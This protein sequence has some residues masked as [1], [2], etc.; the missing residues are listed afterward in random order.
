MAACAEDESPAGTR[1][2]ALIALLYAAGGLRRAEVVALNREDYDR[3]TGALTVR[4]KGRKERLVY[5]DNG[6]QDAL[7]DWLVLRGDEPGPLFWP[8]NKGGVLQERRL[9][10]QAVYNLL[11]KRAAGGVVKPVSPHDLRRT[12]VSDLL[13]AGAMT[14]AAPSSATC[15]RPGPTSAPWPSWPVTPRSRPP[16]ATTAAAKPPSSGPAGCCMSPGG[17]GCE[18]KKSEGSRRMR[19]HGSDC[20]AQSNGY[21]PFTPPPSL[22]F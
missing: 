22:P 16:P 11:R 12:F 7:E 14:C 8:V 9:T 3:E 13:E 10:G 5:V 17:D 1:D 6:A 4:G 18:A 15:W 19:P 20:P 21:L 2:A